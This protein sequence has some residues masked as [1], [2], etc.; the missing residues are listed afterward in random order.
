M[1]LL[2]ISLTELLGKKVDSQEVV[3][4]FFTRMQ[5]HNP[6]LH[7]FTSIV[8]TMPAVENDRRSKL[9]NGMPL[10]F[11][12]NIVTK[13]LPTTASSK[14]LEGYMSPYDATIVHKLA[15]DGATI[16]GKTNMDAWAHGSSTET[17]DFGLTRNPYNL[18]FVPGGSSGG[19]AAAVAAGLI[20]AAIGTETAGSI[21]LPAAWSGVVGLKPSYGRVSRYGIVAMGSSWD[22]PGPITQTVEDAALLLGLMAGYDKHDAT[23]RHEHVP[24]YIETLHH[25]K[26]LTIGIAEEYFDNVDPEIMQH[27]ARAMQLLQQQ[28]HTL[29]KIK[30]LHPKYAI[31]VYMLLQR[32]EVSSNLARYDGIRFGNKR[33]FFGKEAERR[34]LLGT[35]AL[36]AGYYDAFYKKAQKVRYLI[37]EDFERVFKNVD[38]IFA[39]TAPITATKIGDSE[40]FAFYG[41]MMDVLTEPA[42]AAGIPAISIPMGVHSN[43]LPIGGQFMGKYLDEETV[44]NIAAQ[45]EKEIKFDRVSVMEKYD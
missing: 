23:T 37:R 21:R 31:S 5:K 14:V 4:Y 6:S 45:L 17:S 30:L 19:S 27:I 13:Y 34:I 35:Y 15:H 20:P 44:L 16:L 41:E 24:S 3:K 12:D 32:S 10:V 33:S 38:V 18:A 11:K 7:A 8:K 43:G 25:K 1:N 2:G 36:S 9:L 39:P 42:S 22:S 29:K 40:K 28:G 26:K